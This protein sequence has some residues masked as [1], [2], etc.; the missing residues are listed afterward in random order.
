MLIVLIAS[1]YLISQSGVFAKLTADIKNIGAP[2]AANPNATGNENPVPGAT[3]PTPTA[4]QQTPL[5]STPTSQ[6]PSSTIF[7]SSMLKDVPGTTAKIL[8]LKF[9]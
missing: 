6:Q 9:G 4:Q 5:T 7:G 8:G 3:N 1:V 2:P